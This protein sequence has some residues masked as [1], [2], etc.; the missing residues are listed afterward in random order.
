[1]VHVE[2]TKTQKKYKLLE[3]RL[4][5]IERLNASKGMGAVELTLVPDLVLPPKFKTP[6][7]EKFNGG[8]S[9]Y[10]LSEDDRIYQQ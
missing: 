9:N 6:E 5:A 4:K 7:F 3:E 1:M 2:S 10:V 8:P